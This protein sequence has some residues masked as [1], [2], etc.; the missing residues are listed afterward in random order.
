MEAGE[1]IEETLHRE[2]REELPGIPQFEI[3]DILFARRRAEPFANG[4]EF[5]L[6]Y[7][8]VIVSE[9][10][11][12]VSDEHS[13]YEWMGL[14]EIGKLGEPYREVYQGFLKANT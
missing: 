2:L 7:Y 11:V 12:Q 8:R 4:T 3:G 14:E 1:S 10:E 5:C 13:G 9:F 6:L